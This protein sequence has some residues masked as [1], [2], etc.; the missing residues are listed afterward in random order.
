MSNPQYAPNG[1]NYH[2]HLCTCPGCNP[3]PPDPTPA[4]ITQY[5]A[6]MVVD[7]VRKGVIEKLP[8][9]Y[10]LHKDGIEEALEKIYERLLVDPAKLAECLRFYFDDKF[11]PVRGC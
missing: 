11:D 5:E 6:R 4:E 1:S 9:E 2:D 8:A 7:A 10:E 3:Q